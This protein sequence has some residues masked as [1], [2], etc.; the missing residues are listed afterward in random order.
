[1][2][3]SVKEQRR[4]ERLREYDAAV[5]EARSALAVLALFVQGRE[6]RAGGDSLEETF[7]ATP[8]E[9]ADGVQPLPAAIWVALRQSD[10]DATV[11]LLVQLSDTPFAIAAHEQVDDAYRLT[12]VEE[13]RGLPEVNRLVLQLSAA[14]QIPADVMAVVAG[15]G[16][17][18]PR[19]T[20]E[21]DALLNR[22]FGPPTAAPL[23][24]SAPPPQHTDD[25]GRSS[26][27]AP[28]TAAKTAEG[29]L[30][31]SASEFTALLNMSPEQRT[32]LSSL[33]RQTTITISGD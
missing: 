14:L 19:T 28:A 29:G 7:A 24:P 16:A 8:P 26:P 23:A 27:P 9:N 11:Q 33:V 3:Q 18:D 22:R 1:M 5:A 4:R 15:W 2:G 31:M 17:D 25:S 32:V 6:A 10:L 12:T 30:A 21:I 13:N 20:S